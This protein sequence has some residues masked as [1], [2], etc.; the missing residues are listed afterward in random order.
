MQKT[1]YALLATLMASALMQQVSASTGDEVGRLD[2]SMSGTVRANTKCSFSS[3]TGEVDFGTISFVNLGASSTIGPS[4]PRPLLTPVCTGPHLPA[5]MYLEGATVAMG[6]DTLLKT[7]NDDL[8]IQLLVNGTK[9]NVGTSGKFD[10]NTAALPSLTV[11]LVQIKPAG[12][13][14]R[15]NATFSASGS[16]H[17]EFP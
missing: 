14:L 10:V 6:S 3:H 16:L 13:S 15:D 5:K 7:D 1:R 2:I 4:S 17:M 9:Q 8:G 12:T 11:R